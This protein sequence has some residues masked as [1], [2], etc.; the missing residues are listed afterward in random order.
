VDRAAEAG[1]L[2]LSVGATPFGFGVDDPA[3]RSGCL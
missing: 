3:A 1:R 2:R